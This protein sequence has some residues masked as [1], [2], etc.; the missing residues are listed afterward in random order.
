MQLMNSN[1]GV[2]LKYNYN[3]YSL[4]FGSKYTCTALSFC[5]SG[6]SI[7]GNCYLHI[8][9]GFTPICS[10][11]FVACSS[12]RVNCFSR[13]ACTYFNGILIVCT[14]FPFDATTIQTYFL[15]KSFGSMMI[16]PEVMTAYWRPNTCP[17]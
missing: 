7:A 13:I 12:T 2:N 10:R 11:V 17:K 14:I 6:M 8:L 3:N 16:I 4:L 9:I 15:T 5:A 1:F